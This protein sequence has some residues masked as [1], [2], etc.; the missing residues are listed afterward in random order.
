MGIIPELAGHISNQAARRYVHN[1]LHPAL[2]RIVRLVAPHFALAHGELLHNAAGVLLAD[3]N[4]AFLD[5]FEPDAA[6]QCFGILLRA[7]DHHSFRW[8]NAELETLTA[9]G[10]QQDTE[11]EDAAAAQLEGLR[12]GPGE[13]GQRHVGFGL[14]VYPVADNLRGEFRAFTAS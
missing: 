3:D 8:A 13:D 2:L 5:R 12:G 14:F 9:E 6:G 7:G 11:M 10:F 4:R 1:D